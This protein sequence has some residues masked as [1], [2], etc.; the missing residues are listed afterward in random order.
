VL[1]TWLVARVAVTRLSFISVVAPMIALLL[2]IVVRHERPAPLSA[3]GALAVLMGV[4][5]GL[6]LG[7]IRMR[8]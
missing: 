8:P 2:G 1:W 5:I 6:E 3:V 7:P 4:A